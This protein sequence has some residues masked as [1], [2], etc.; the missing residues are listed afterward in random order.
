MGMDQFP[1]LFLP[2]GFDNAPISPAMLITKD[3]KTGIRN[4]GNYRAMIKA[5]I[6][7]A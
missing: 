6:N 3:P 2:P 1:V 4:V 5:E 7:L